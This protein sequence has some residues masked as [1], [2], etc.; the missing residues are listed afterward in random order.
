MYQPSERL[1]SIVIPTPWRTA[2]AAPS[3]ATTYCADQEPPSAVCSVTPSALA[4]TS[5]TAALNTISTLARLHA[6]SSNASV[7]QLGRLVNWGTLAGS[8]GG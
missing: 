5:V 1:P 2:E 3:A 6:S 7:R 8:R 4:L